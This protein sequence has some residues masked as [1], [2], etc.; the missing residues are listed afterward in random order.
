MIAAKYLQLKREEI[1]DFDLLEDDW[2][3]L[4][5]RLWRIL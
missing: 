1:S 2:K 4:R 5:R 3:A